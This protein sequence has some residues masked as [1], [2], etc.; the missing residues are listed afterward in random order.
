MITSGKKREKGGGGTMKRT[1]ELL[2]WKIRTKEN[3][4]SWEEDKIN[5]SRNRERGRG[6]ERPGS[7]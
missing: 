3:P 2:S 5:V 7:G 1:I 6:M 4:G